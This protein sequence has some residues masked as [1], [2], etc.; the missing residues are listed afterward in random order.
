MYKKPAAIFL[1]SLI[2]SCAANA[3]IQ[4]SGSQCY[5][6]EQLP[7]QLN[8]VIINAKLNLDESV[9]YSETWGLTYNLSKIPDVGDGNIMMIPEFPLPAGSDIYPDVRVTD[10]IGGHELSRVYFFEQNCSD[11]FIYN[12]HENTV[13]LCIRPEDQIRMRIDAKILSKNDLQT[14]ELLEKKSFNITNPITFTFPN[15]SYQYL[16]SMQIT[17]G[18][19]VIIQNISGT[20]CRDG[21]VTG[22]A[23]SP[24]RLIPVDNGI[25]CQGTIKPQ[26]PLLKV[27]S[28]TGINEKKMQEIAAQALSQLQMEN[29]NASIR[30]SDAAVATSKATYMNAYLTIAIALL[31]AL[32]I[33][34]LIQNMREKGK[35]SRPNV[36]VKLDPHETD[37]V[38]LKVVNI[39]KTAAIDIDM[40]YSLKPGGESYRWHHH[41]MAEN[42]E[43]HFTPREYKDLTL[44]Q[45]LGKYAS[46][47]VRTHWKDPQGK[48]FFEEYAIDLRNY[49]KSIE[50][51]IQVWREKDSP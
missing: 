34:L 13:E 51:N 33:F 10:V 8:E 4:C 38:V 45:F 20:I 32:N 26:K 44:K 28:L 5:G 36:K 2:L 43:T 1:A 16:A 22:A 11:K 19:G 41:L 6:S 31:T 47:N 30:A 18:D 46:I 48:K 14:Y 15:S 21:D 35:S 49:Q 25:I 24:M 12:P 27:L 17:G 3:D 40:D 29:I 50:S 39:G 7:L 9:D 42:E 23:S 37:K